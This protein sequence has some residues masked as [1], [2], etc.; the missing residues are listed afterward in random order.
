MQYMSQPPL[1][2]G[3]MKYIGTIEY[4]EQTDEIFHEA[5]RRALSGVPGPTMVTV[6]PATVA[7]SASLLLKLNAPG[8]LLVGAL[9]VNVASPS[10]LLM[11]GKSPRVGPSL[12]PQA[13]SKVVNRTA[14]GSTSLKFIVGPR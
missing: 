10:V 4:P 7:T 6:S 5:F 1:F 8:P 14:A 13:A 12:P 2:E 9:S 11:A 3:A